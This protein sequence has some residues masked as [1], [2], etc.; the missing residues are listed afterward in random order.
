[1]KFS[2]TIDLHLHSTFSDGV[3]KPSELV[4]MAKVEG[5]SA[6]AITDHDTAA[7]TCE[8]LERGKEQGVEVVPGIEISSWLNSTSMHI[9]GYWFNHDDQQFRDRLH[10]LQ[11]G[12]NARNVKIIDNLNRLG[13]NV[14][15]DDLQKY[16]KYGQTGRPHIARLLVD[17]GKVKTVDQ[18]FKLYLGRGAAA[19]AER[20]KFEAHDAIGM[21]REAGG[22]AVLAHPANLDPSLR[23]MPH[24]LQSLK[25]IGLRGMEVYYPSHTPNI[26]KALLKMAER[27]GLLITGGSDYHGF[28]RSGINN[29]GGSTFYHASYDLVKTMKEYRISRN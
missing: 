20:F 21:I 29:K 24:L 3:L 1:M 10:K 15:I 27:F 16:S 11:N 4:D 9:L 2:Q 8:A 19:Y 13:I 6:I 25:D 26:V 28:D 23:T 7:G 5:L 22:I 17:T 12:R 14:S 18:A